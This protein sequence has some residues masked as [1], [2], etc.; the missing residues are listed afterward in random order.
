MKKNINEMILPGIVTLV[1]LAA[2]LI[3]WN[4]LPAQ[5]ATHFAFDGTPDGWTSRAFTVFGIP[6]ILLALLLVCAIPLRSK[7]EAQ[8]GKLGAMVLWII[9]SVSILL[10]VTVYGYALGNTM[11]DSRVGCLFIGLLLMVI[12]N[13]MPKVRRNRYV[14]IRTPWTLADE[15][16][17]NKTHRFT[18]PI[19]VV[20]GG[21]LAFIG[22]VGIGSGVMLLVLLMI[23]VLAPFAYSF[24]LS[25]KK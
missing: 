8:A 2:G 5:V 20:G 18:A 17:W 11:N 21:L 15:T 22:G 24:A 7:W 19:W 14:G 4:K 13:Y 1:P 16:N 12:G 3:L 10:T 9:P 6:L 23:M 25:R